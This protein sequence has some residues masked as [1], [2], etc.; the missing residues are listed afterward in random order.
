M[1]PEPPLDP[2]NPVMDAPAAALAGSPPFAGAGRA[3]PLVRSVPASAPAVDERELVARA[4]GRDEEAFRMLVELHQDR[5]VGLALRITRSRPDAEDVAQEA[6]VRAWLALPGFRGESSFGTWLH[7][8]VARRA[9]D[10]SQSLRARRGR[11]TADEDAG[12]QAPAPE[13]ASRDPLLADRLER[14]MG[15]LNPVQRAVVTLFY[16]EDRSVEDVARA[17]DLPENTVKTH[18]SR[19]RALLR[20]AWLRE[21]G[22]ETA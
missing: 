4:R 20:E 1:K 18:L 7:R 8:I 19:A 6:F 2:S 22:E 13:P 21:H 3:R 12:V 5:A 16:R 10:R 15:V 11:E 14:L 17:L 9:I